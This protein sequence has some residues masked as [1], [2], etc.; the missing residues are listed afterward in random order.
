MR[1]GGD[2]G[3]RDPG[4]DRAPDAVLR[5]EAPGALAAPA[6]LP[7]RRGRGPDP[8]APLAERPPPDAGPAPGGRLARPRPRAGRRPPGR[9]GPRAPRPRRPRP[10]PPGRPPPP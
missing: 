4:G 8:G 5:P 9:P 2:E 7:G 1:I 10:A 6:Q 3:G